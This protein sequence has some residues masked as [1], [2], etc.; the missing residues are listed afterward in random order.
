M[1]NIEAQRIPPFIHFKGSIKYIRD[2]STI[3]INAS[4][5]VIYRSRQLSLS[6]LPSPRYL[7]SKGRINHRN[8]VSLKFGLMELESRT[9]RDELT[10][11]EDDARLLITPINYAW[12]SRVIFSGNKVKEGVMN[13]AVNCEFQ[14]QSSTPCYDFIL[15]RVSSCC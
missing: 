11:H 1:W 6:P 12:N 3:N 10:T 7:A 13:P 14:L 9:T 5:N 2:L 4:L 8:T 15:G